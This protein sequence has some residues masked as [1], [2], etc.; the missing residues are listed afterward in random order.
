MKV[1]PVIELEKED[2]NALWLYAEHAGRIPF[3]TPELQTL[4]VEF[5]K[6]LTAFANRMFQAG[7]EY[8][9]KQCTKN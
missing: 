3:G 5:R 2:G 9:R 4:S 1:I 8:E 7:I 6:E